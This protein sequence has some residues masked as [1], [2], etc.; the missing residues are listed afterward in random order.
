MSSNNLPAMLPQSPPFGGDT[1]PDPRLEE[2]LS[3]QPVPI[4]EV[5]VPYQQLDFEETDLGM[6]DGRYTVLN[7][8]AGPV[9]RGGEAVVYK[10]SVDAED[11]AR[12]AVKV[13]ERY[14]LDE[15]RI[16]ETS[17][18]FAIHGLFSG[19]DAHPQIV[20]FLFGNEGNLVFHQTMERWKS[21]RGRC[22]SRLPSCWAN[23][24]TLAHQLS[25]QNG[26]KE[27]RSSA[28]CLS[29]AKMVAAK[30]KRCGS[31]HNLRKALR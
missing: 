4:P 14:I 19:D 21:T 22:L 20:D 9:A 7:P 10:A 30:R 29:S 1:Q 18:E 24:C 26:W 3:A 11:T 15:R 27:E 17:K 8:E 13:M 6:I 28:L 2:E 5:H 12:V 23:H 16:E 25:S 31:S